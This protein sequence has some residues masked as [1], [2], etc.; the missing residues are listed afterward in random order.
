MM[1]KFYWIFV[2]N[3]RRKFRLQFIEMILITTDVT[4]FRLIFGAKC[5]IKIYKTYTLYFAKATQMKKSNR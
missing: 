1:I 3:E 4:I 5:N 2:D